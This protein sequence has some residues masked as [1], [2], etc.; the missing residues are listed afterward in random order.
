MRFLAFLTLLA[1]TS[2][3]TIYTGT[4]QIVH[5]DSSEQGAEVY[6]NDDKIGTTPFTYRIKRKA[7]KQEIKI[8]KKN[9]EDYTANLNKDFRPISILS[10]IYIPVDFVTG[11]AWKYK[12][13]YINADLVRSSDKQTNDIRKSLFYIVKNDGDTIY[14]EPD[15]TWSKK[16][17]KYTTLDG[18]S[19]KMQWESI[20]EHQ[21]LDYGRS[22]L[23]F[24]FLQFKLKDVYGVNKFSVIPVD[25]TKRKTFIRPMRII[26][27][28][29]DYSIM[30]D[31]YTKSHYN[32]DGS[33]VS[34][35]Y[36][37]YYLYKGKIEQEE[38]KNKNCVEITQKYFSNNTE[39]I[40]ML[41]KKSK[42]K[43]FYKYYE[44][45]RDPY[46]SL[47]Y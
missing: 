42:V 41:K 13:E 12:E 35:K 9:Y 4:K 11:A 19:S 18:V 22:F 8:T 24:A 15:H 3:A 44:E 26:A 28:N 2:C 14:T 37:V 39:L 38:I 10:T 32:G 21:N 20:N 31:Q 27:K 47:T 29:G 36:F 17:L 6:L 34:Y 30:E 7:S 43:T 5:F 45:I 40:S 46:E 16:Y 23:G 25:S 33:G 1:C